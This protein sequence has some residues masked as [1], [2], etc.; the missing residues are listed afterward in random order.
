MEPE[1]LRLAGIFALAMMGGSTLAVTPEE[2][3]ANNAGAGTRTRQLAAS[4]LIHRLL[5]LDER[6]PELGVRAQLK[7]ILDEV[8]RDHDNVDFAKKLA[9][10]VV[11]MKP[12]LEAQRSNPQ[13]E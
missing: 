5:A 11:S 3:Q 12:Y 8:R 4:E 2:E 13:D 1:T 7:A 9:P 6:R 10:I